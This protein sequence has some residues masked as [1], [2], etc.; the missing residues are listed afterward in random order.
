VEQLSNVSVFARRNVPFVLPLAVMLLSAALLVSYWLDAYLLGL[1]HGLVAATIVGVA[2]SMVRGPKGEQGIADLLRSARKEHQVWGWVDDVEVQG[3]R[4]DHLVVTREGGVVAIDSCWSSDELTPELLAADAHRALLAARR[5]A[6]VL[7]TRDR[8]PAVRPLL[9][10]WGSIQADVKKL[11]VR[12]L[13]GV[14]LLAGRELRA[15]L[16]RQNGRPVE[17]GDA[18]AILKGLRGHRRSGGVA[19]SAPAAAPWSDTTDLA[20][21]SDAAS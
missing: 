10:Y 8:V 1:V 3:D 16:R 6:Q 12:N 13:E 7:V 2:A 15:W 11:P 18:R 20:F 4:V 5:A 14:E 9:V 21:A 17:R 19:A